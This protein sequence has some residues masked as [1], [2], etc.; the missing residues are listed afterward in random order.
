MSR[1]PF[2]YPVVQLPDAELAREREVYGG[3]AQAVRR[4]NEVSLRST[5]PDDVVA[6]ARD[7]VEQATR[8]LEAETV[9]GAVGVQITSDGTMLGHGN[10][11]V[12]MRN[13]V[14]VP[15]HVVQDHER[16]RATAEFEL[17]ALHEGPPGMVHGGVSALVLDQLCGEAAA[18]AGH[19]G[20]TG[21]LSLRYR[22][23]LPLGPVSAEARFVRLEG[24]RAIVEG[25]LRNADGQVCVEVEG[26]F[27]LP[28]WAREAFA[29]QPPQF[30]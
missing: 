25:E 22:R 18:A 15:V 3:L 27:I 21:T 30:E 4:L 26:V 16:G 23:P 24:V 7:L 11:V 6:K 13:P 12:G 20:M 2:E 19:P 17:N 1:A 5:V 10:A 8:L 28:R 14:A 9:P 29:T